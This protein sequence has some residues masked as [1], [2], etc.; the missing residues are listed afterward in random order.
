MPIPMVVNQEAAAPTRYLKKPV[1]ETRILDIMEDL[2]HWNH[3]GEGEMLLT[4]ER[5]KDGKHALR[6]VSP[7]FPDRPGRV[8]EAGRPHGECS[9]LR[10]F[11]AEDWTGFEPAVLPGLSPPTGLPGHLAP[12]QLHNAGTVKV[13]DEYGREGLHYFLLKNDQWNHVVVEIA[14]WL[15][16]K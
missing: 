7:S 5:A 11:D 1:I 13:P 6:L 14:H 8:G 4:T 16:T 9:A 10:K 2:T 3:G 12:G 15:A